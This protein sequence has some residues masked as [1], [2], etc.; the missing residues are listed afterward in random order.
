MYL[1]KVK[2]SKSAVG[3]LIAVVV[4]FGYFFP[5]PANQ[6]TNFFY[7]KNNIMFPLILW[8]APFLICFYL[9]MLGFEKH[10]GKLLLV[11][12]ALA[13]ISG[14]PRFNDFNSVN[15]SGQ[16]YPLKLFYVFSSFAF[17]YFLV[18][19]FYFLERIG[20]SAINYFLAL[21]RLLGDSTLA[22]YI[23]HWIIV[24][25]T[26]WIFYPRVDLI[27][28]S[29]PIFLLIYVISKKRKLLEYFKSYE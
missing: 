29:A 3:A 21:F 19:A 23:Y 6:L 12:S 8:L 11:F 16:M 14:V 2:Y 17:M 18:Y 24:D 27:W 5:M 25:I 20:R 26:L 10:K 7:A 28:L 9:S 22:I 1:S 15:F 4:Y 13:M